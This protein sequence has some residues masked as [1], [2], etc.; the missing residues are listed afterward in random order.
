MRLFLAVVCS[1]AVASAALGQVFYSNFGGLANPNAIGLSTGAVTNSGVNAPAGFEWSECPNNNPNEAN[2]VAGFSGFKNS[3]LDFRLAD[4]F[5]IL[6]GQQFTIDAVR[7]YA[8]RTGAPAAEQPFSG[9]T[10][11]IWDGVPG[12]SGSNIIYGDTTT[13]VLFN[14]QNTNLYRIFSTVAPPPGSAP[15]TTRLVREAYL[16]VNNITLGPGTYWL[17]WQLEMLVGTNTS[18]APPISIPGVR[19]LPSWNARQWVG[20]PTNAW[21]AAVD[22]GNPAAAPDYV[23]DFPFLLE[24]SWVP[25]PAS[26][27]LLGLAGLL[28]RRR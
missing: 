6:P 11:R 26:L 5:T 27:L 18:F 15:G 12:A 17:D 21:Q 23:Q 22:T 3:T 13:N 16:F 25:E 19:G 10:L 24:G 4:D 8:Y 2:T 20:A 14:V 28:I 1:V 7:V 9:G